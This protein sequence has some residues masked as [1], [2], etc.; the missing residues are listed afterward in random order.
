MKDLV[1]AIVVDVRCRGVKYRFVIFK[2]GGMRRL[3]E[4]HHVNGSKGIKNYL[5]KML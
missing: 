1:V 5:N 3:T 2:A 4:D